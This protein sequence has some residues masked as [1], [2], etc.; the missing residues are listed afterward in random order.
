MKYLDGY[1]Q[2]YKY[3][4]SLKANGVSAKSLEWAQNNCK[5]RFGWY[6]RDKEA[7]VTFEN[8]KDAFYWTLKWY[9]TSA[10]VSRS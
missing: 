4:V 1:L 9:E 6:F 3:Q 7:I 5:E 2:Q 8:A 10:D